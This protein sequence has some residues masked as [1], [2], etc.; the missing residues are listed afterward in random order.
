VVSGEGSESA[1]LL[2]SF[3]VAIAPPVPEGPPPKI[4]SLLV[5]NG[6]GL[7]SVLDVPVPSEGEGAPGEEGQAAIAV[8]LAGGRQADG[9]RAG[10]LL[11]GG[12][13]G[14]VEAEDEAAPAAGGPPSADVLRLMIGA[15]EAVKGIDMGTADPAGG[16][17]GRLEPENELLATADV[18]KELRVRRVDA[19]FAAGVAD[20]RRVGDGGTAP[21]HSGLLEL[22]ATEPIGMEPVAWSEG[23][24]SAD[25]PAGV[26]SQAEVWLLPC[27]VLAHGWCRGKAEERANRARRER[28]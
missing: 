12:G 7:P 19:V 16:A 5:L 1:L 11:A 21:V 17:A 23:P 25:V 28:E 9:D 2:T 15:D 24:G 26:G 22:P 10:A 3:G 8:R 20:V 4:P 6:P 27:L 18:A 14:L 13:E